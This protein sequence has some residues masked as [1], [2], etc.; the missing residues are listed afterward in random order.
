MTETKPKTFVVD[1]LVKALTD[2][3]GQVAPTQV[4][5]GF[6]GAKRDDGSVRFYLEP[7][8]Q[9]WI[10]LQPSAIKHSVK[11]KAAQSS[12]GG[13]LIWLDQNIPCQ[14]QIDEAPT[15]ELTPTVDS[16]SQDSASQDSAS[17]DSASQDSASQADDSQGDDSQ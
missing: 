16:A 3:T 9:Q 1:D 2:A 8:L 11:L 10:D 5:G 15:S 6:M 4:V 14:Q 12:I 17:Q 7:T 13:T